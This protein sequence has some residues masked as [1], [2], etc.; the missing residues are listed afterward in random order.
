MLEVK[1][2][3]GKMSVQ[4]YLGYMAVCKQDFKIK[5]PNDS[6]IYEAIYDF[7]HAELT[8]GLLIGHIVD[9]MGEPHFLVSRIVDINKEEYTTDIGVRYVYKGVRS[10][11][12]L[13]RGDSRTLDDLPTSFFKIE[14]DDITCIL[15]RVIT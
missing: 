4:T 8:V 12:V 9:L 13:H 2:S 10:I 1:S 15:D 6:R 5:I 7:I 14:I 3:D 11:P